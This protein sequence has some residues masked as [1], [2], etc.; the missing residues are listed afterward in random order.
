MIENE[1]TNWNRLV[2]AHART[3]THSNTHAHQEC[4]VCKVQKTKF[5]NKVFKELA[6]FLQMR[7]KVTNDKKFKWLKSR[8]LVKPFPRKGLNLTDLGFW[9]WPNDNPETRC[10]KYQTFDSFDIAITVTVEGNKKFH[11]KNCDYPIKRKL[12]FRVTITSS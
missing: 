2:F 8:F 9:K 7:K 3:H 11:P 5:G 1:R 4:Q 6:Q 10:L 12:L